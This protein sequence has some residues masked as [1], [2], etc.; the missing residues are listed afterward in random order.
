LIAVHAAGVGVWDTKIRD[1]S[2]A[3]GDIHFPLIMGTS[4]D[5]LRSGGRVAYPNGVEPAPRKRARIRVKGYDAEVNRAALQRLGRAAETAQLEV[6]IAASYPLARA[7]QAHR[8]VE[9]G[10]VVGRVVLRIR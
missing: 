1:G 5:L 2:W 9:R 4:I 8:R 3:E 10:H 7:S 6:P